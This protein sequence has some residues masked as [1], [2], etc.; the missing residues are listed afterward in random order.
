MVFN[1]CRSKSQKYIY[2]YLHSKI[3]KK[4]KSETAAVKQ[5]VLDSEIIGFKKK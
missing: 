3:D 1:D 4:A 5:V 2:I